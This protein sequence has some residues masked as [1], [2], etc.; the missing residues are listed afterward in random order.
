MTNAKTLMTITELAWDDIAAH[1][2]GSEIGVVVLVLHKVGDE[3][4][5]QI[6]ANVPPEVVKF[7]IGKLNEE[8]AESSAF[9]VYPPP[10][11]RHAV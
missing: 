8:W 3:L 6:G 10:K 2:D 5:T 1:G 11:R 7:T 9:T 4:L